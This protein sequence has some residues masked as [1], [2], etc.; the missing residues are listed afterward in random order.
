MVYSHC[1]YSSGPDIF[2]FLQGLCTNDFNL[3]D[4]AEDDC[5]QISG[6]ATAF[7]NPKGRIICEAIATR[8]CSRHGNSEPEVLLDLGIDSIPPLLKHL[9]M[10]KL[11]KK[12]QMEDA[13]ETY[14]VVA[15]AGGHAQETVMT[16]VSSVLQPEAPWSVVVD[17]R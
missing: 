17:P 7:L 9:R 12:I 1:A 16:A 8:N 11:R 10:H 6:L 4:T 2:K 13:T 3:L 14:G 15:F 5:T